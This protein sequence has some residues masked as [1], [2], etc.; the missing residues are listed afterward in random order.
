MERKRRILQVASRF[1]KSWEELGLA[2]VHSEWSNNITLYKTSLVP[3]KTASIKLR[4]QLQASSNV[5]FTSF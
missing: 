1:G 3:Q 2:N 4:V 5:V